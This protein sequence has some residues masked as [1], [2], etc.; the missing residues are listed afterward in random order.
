MEKPKPHTFSATRKPFK[1]QI[2][3]KNGAVVTGYSEERKNRI[4]Y[5]SRFTTPIVVTKGDVFYMDP[6]K[7]FILNG[8]PVHVNMTP[9]KKCPVKMAWASNRLRVAVFLERDRVWS[10]RAKKFTKKMGK[11][12]WVAM[13][14]RSY[15]LGCG[16]DVQTALVRLLQ[17]LQFTQLMDKEERQKGVNVIRWHCERQKDVRATLKEAEEKA[18]KTGFI[19]EGIDW[20]ESVVGKGKFKT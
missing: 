2:D 13:D 14:T 18:K 16:E 12:Y 11:P 9:A 5:Y 15:W 1:V 17:Q 3:F 8:I 4:Y 10:K 7:G 19:L 20:Q 6:K